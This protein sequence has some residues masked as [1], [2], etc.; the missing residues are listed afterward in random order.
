MAMTLI[1][2]SL[3]LL[4]VALIAVLGALSIRDHRRR[5]AV[6]A[7]EG[8][9]RSGGVAFRLMSSGPDKGAVAPRRYMDDSA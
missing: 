7:P 5:R 2:L 9:A 1:L 4:V 8:T 6:G 3:T